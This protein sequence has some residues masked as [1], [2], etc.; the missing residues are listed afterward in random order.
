MQRKNPYNEDLINIIAIGRL[1]YVKGFDILL[2]AFKIVNEKIPNTH[3]TILGEGE[4]KNELIH[5]AE[6]FNILK[7]ITFVN[8]TNNLYPYLFY[9]DTF[10]LSSRW[11]GFPNTLLEALA[12]HAKV[13]ATDCKNGP[14]EIL[15]N[16]KYGRL[17]PTEDYISLAEGII[18]SINDS[19][20]SK[21]RAADFDIEKIV[22][23]YE[24]LF[25]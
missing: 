25:I 15:D 6:K 19:N 20:R 9:S 14:R 8:F 7:N 3:L 11:E 23:Q 13:V 24:E 5:Q 12:C 16:N 17:V 2:K 4:L 18:S 22:K 1:T 10:V 21:D